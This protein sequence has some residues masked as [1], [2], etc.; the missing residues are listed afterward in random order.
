MMPINA[1][2]VSV[3]RH[4]LRNKKSRALRHGPSTREA[5]PPGGVICGVA[6]VAI[7]ILTSGTYPHS[8]MLGAGCQEGFFLAKR[9]YT[10]YNNVDKLQF[11]VISWR[12]IGNPGY[13]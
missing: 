2:L 5:V 1:T 12:K 9:K 4:L 10:L 6:S 13:F 11:G 7:V 8:M 3:C